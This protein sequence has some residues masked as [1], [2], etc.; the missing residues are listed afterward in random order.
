MSMVS[1][2]CPGRRPIFWSKTRHSRS[3]EMRLVESGQW[4]SPGRP[5]GPEHGQGIFP[6]A[7]RR[8]CRLDQIVDERSDEDRLARPRKS[9]DAETN[10]RARRQLDEGLRRGAG[11]EQE[12]GDQRQSKLAFQSIS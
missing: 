1:D 11:F 3:S 8:A 2:W 4:R 6:P 10:M 5:L 12:V 9:G 7:Q